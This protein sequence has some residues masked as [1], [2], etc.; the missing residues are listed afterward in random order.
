MPALPGDSSRLVSEL[1]KLAKALQ[2]TIDNG[3]PEIEI[4]G[5]AGIEE[6]AAGQVTFVSNPKYAAAARTTRASAVIVSEASLHPRYH[7]AFKIPTSPLR[8][9]SS[10]SISLPLMFPES[11]R[12]P[13]FIQL[14]RLALR[15]I[16][17]RM[18]SWSATSP[19]A[20]KQRC[21]PRGDL[22]RRT[23]W[24]PFFRPCPFG[25]PRTLPARQ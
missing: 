9:R 3:S 21:S 12:L 23:H 7:V 10:S 11:I 1:S 18:L 14:P 15:H 2:A 22:S 20:R 8:A 19:S 24:R 4:T 16:L 5:V 6:A 25:R 17:D 13:W